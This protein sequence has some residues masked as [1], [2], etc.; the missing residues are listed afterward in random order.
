MRSTV[1]VVGAVLAFAGVAS[2]D[3]MTIWQDNFDGYANQAAFNAVYTQINATNVV[4]LDQAKGFSDGQSITQPTATSGNGW[5]AWKNLGGEFDGSDEF[6]LKVEF[7]I[8]MDIT[9]DFFTRNWI[10][11]RAYS[12]AGYLDGTLE[13][14]LALG[15]A[16]SG[17]P[18]TT[19]Y[20]GRVTFGPQ[21]GWFS[22]NTAK[23]ADWTK[24]AIVV[25]TS[26]VEFWVNDQLDSVKN[27]TA[28]RTYD[29]IVIGSSFSSR[30]QVW[31]DDL[32]VSILP[33]PAT[34]TFL[35]LGGLFLRRRRA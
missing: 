30:V 4:T 15:C 8:D 34:L 18:D 14:L 11:L 16:S 10:E 5:R 23:S 3:L 31:Y 27:D 6:P 29:S 32:K 35:A 1:L 25:K 33:E 9:N 21:T 12:G 2:A 7:M 28:G 24:L 19:K 26:T 13:Q 17:V 20:A 22:M